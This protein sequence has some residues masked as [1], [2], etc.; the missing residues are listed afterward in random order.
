[1]PARLS[2]QQQFA[3]THFLDV[4]QSDSTTALSIL[5]QHNFNVETALNDFFTRS[6]VPMEDMSQMESVFHKYATD[7]EGTK[8]IL[9]EGFSQ[10][11][12]D[13]GIDPGN[14]RWLVFLWKSEAAI[15]GEITE[16][17]FIRGCRKVGALNLPHFS[18]KL[19]DM[20]HYIEDNRSFKQFYKWLFD[21]LKVDP[22]H[23]SV[24]VDNAVHAWR[25]VLTD[26]WSLTEDWCNFV[27]QQSK[28]KVVTR[29][30][31]NE[32]L[33]FIETVGNDL[34]KW[35]ADD[36]WPSAIDQ[37]CELKLV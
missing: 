28:L 17:E 21:Y 2:R 33:S 14:I 35:S 4:T 6:P 25:L 5:R 30:L 26:R 13:V 10:L 7:I 20:L 12:E 18:Q 36:A 29:D 16:E 24:T 32:L 22:E 3:L 8:T 9:F 1:M 27:S 31:W 11:A 23:K 15:M 37:F 34:T 19:A